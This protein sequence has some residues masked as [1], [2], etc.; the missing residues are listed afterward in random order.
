MRDEWTIEKVAERFEECASVLNRL[1]DNDI[2]GYSTYWPEI[3]Y[4]EKE[5]KRQPVKTLRLRPLPDAIDR[6]EE[7]LQWILYVHEDCRKLVWLRA[8]RTP[9]REI[10]RQ[11]GVSPRSVRRYW[12][13]ELS[14]VAR[15]LVE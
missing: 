5:I 12:D 11:V 3:I 10:A 7:T 15:R 13:R 14:E 6:M 2:S 1:P 9:W 4:T 8:Y